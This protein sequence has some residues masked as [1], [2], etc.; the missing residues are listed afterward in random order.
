MTPEQEKTI[1]QKN[2]LSEQ[3]VAL[4]MQGRWREAIEINNS[5]LA[6]FPQEVNSYNRLGRAYMEIGDYA[7]AREAYNK[8]LEV[9]PYNAIAKKNLH[10]LSIMKEPAKPTEDVEKVEPEQFIEEIGKSGVVNLIAQA[11][12]E[13]RA[14]IV[15]GDKVN[16]KTKGASL[17]VE[18]QTGEYLGQV[19]PRQALRLSKLM[20]GGNRYS[21]T[22]VSSEE[23]AMAVIIRET[24]Q[25]PSQAG[26][27]SFPPKGMEAVQPVGGEHV[28]KL[29][30]EYEREADEE[31]GYTIIGGEESDILPA[32]ES[33]GGEEDNNSDEE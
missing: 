13:I 31:P 22:V 4:A 29:E 14:R 11:P 30:S 21:A 24:Y 10:R 6:D 25:D 23:E 20:A 16:L 1:K 33:A 15:A 12:K 28:L 5:I 7:H 17:T 2:Q 18:S 32:E 8:A 19:D 26:R 27:L 3:A 9:D